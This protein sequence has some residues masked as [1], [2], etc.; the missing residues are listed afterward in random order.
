VDLET[1]K[2][3]ALW[4]IIAVAVIGLVLAIVIKKILGKIISLLVA[5]VLVYIG[6]QQREKVVSYA[7]EVRGKACES[8][9]GAVDNPTTARAT[10]FLGIG[11]SLPAGWCS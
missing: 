8:A 1:I 11:V 5:A 7:E 2:T 6:W 4:A 10:T 3:V 9:A